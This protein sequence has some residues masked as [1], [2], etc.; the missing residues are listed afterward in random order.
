MPV[1]PQDFG[2]STIRIDVPACLIVR[3]PDFLLGYSLCSILRGFLLLL[4]EP[5]AFDYVVLCWQ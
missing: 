5:E 4:P 1:V 3:F 2:V